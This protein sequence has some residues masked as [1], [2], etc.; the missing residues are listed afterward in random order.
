MKVTVAICRRTA[1]RTA[2]SDL[3]VH[4]E[5][6][7]QRALEAAESRTRNVP[8]TGF[9]PK[10]AMPVA[11]VPEGGRPRL[12][13]FDVAATLPPALAGLER[14]A[15]NYWWS[16][17]PEGQGLFQAAAGV[18]EIWPSSKLAA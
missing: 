11:S 12:W 6:A 10:V 7:F 13:R 9:R 4:Y 17:D 2:W 18:K 5:A 8:L 16:W 14:L 1:Q 15:Q 3:I